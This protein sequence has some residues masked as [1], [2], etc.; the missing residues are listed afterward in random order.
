MT[1]KNPNIII[2][3]LDPNKDRLAEIVNHA[4]MAM[5][6]AGFT[7]THAHRIECVSIIGKYQAIIC[8]E[9]R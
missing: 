6:G 8:F 7:L 2:Q 9:G 3:V 4:E 5:A 1:R